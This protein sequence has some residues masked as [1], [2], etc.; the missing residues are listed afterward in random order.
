MSI[1]YFLWTSFIVQRFDFFDICQLDIFLTIWHLFDI[2]TSFWHFDIF[3]NLNHLSPSQGYFSYFWLKIPT[4][5][6]SPTTFYP[7]SPVT[8]L[9]RSPVL[10]PAG[11]L[12]DPPSTHTHTRDRKWGEPS[13][14]RSDATPRAV[15]LLLARRRTFLLFFFLFVNN[16]CKTC[17]KT[18]L[19]QQLP[20]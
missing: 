11:G 20:K 12:Q 4:F 9:D 3:L 2:L 13:P 15:R 17:V 19:L 14:G 10:S 6:T 16:W 8:G 5:L 18:D 7:A 1:Y